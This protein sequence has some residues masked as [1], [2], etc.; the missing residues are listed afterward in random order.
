MSECC[1]KWGLSEQDRYLEGVS[2][3]DRFLEG[4]SEKDRYLGVQEQYRY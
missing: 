4:V 3:Q 1:R 2:E